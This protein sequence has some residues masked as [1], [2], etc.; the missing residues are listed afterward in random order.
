[1]AK[2]MKLR[3][4]EAK[5]RKHGCHVESETG[6]HT[7]WRCPCGKHTANIPRHREISAGVVASTSKRMECLP[8]GWL[9]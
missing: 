4:V 6:P 8:K 9:Q 1:M 5:L 2:A 3:D 7:K